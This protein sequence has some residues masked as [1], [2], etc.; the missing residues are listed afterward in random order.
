MELDPEG[1]GLGSRS[2][3]MPVLNRGHEPATLSRSV[4]SPVDP[5]DRNSSGS[6]RE[7]SNRESDSNPGVGSFLQEVLDLPPPLRRSMRVSIP[8]SRYSPY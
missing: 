6:P 4:S 1:A 3:S 2:V 5:L 7:S 8:T